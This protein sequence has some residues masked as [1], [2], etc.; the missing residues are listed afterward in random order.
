MREPQGN[1][2]ADDAALVGRVATGDTQ[3]YRELVRRHAPG[4][5]RY[6]E[7]LVRDPAEAEDVSQETFLR[8][9]LRARDYDPVARVT[10]WLFRIA[11]NLCVDRLRARGRV[12]LLEQ[13]DAEAAPESAAQPVLLESKQRAESLSAALDALP[14]RQASAVSLVHLHGL[15]GA[16]ACAVLEVSEEALESLLSRGR[17]GLKAQLAGARAV[18]SGAMS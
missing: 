13:P 14:P 16:E 10:T 6:A 5:Q 15:S 8:L 11:H 18:D 9:W 1:S 12:E 4:I 3:A 17:R 2:A 7:R